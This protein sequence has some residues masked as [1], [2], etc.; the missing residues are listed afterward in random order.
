M[1]TTLKE[2]KTKL[3][4]PSYG[5]R[6]TIEGELTFIQKMYSHNVEIYHNSYARGGNHPIY[7]LHNDDE[8]QKALEMNEQYIEM[9][10]ELIEKG[11][12]YQGK[13]S[14][15][16]KDSEG[17]WKNAMLHWGEAPKILK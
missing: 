9:D 12:N 17:N 2:L 8:I 7:T 14:Y 11:F 6:V 13:G 15:A 5:G 10:K 3:E 1:K 16:K 4:S